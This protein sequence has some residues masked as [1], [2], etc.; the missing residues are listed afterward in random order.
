MDKIENL[1]R[2]SKTTANKIEIIDLLD[3]EKNQIGTKVII[4][5][6]NV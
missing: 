3:N 4:Q 5:L 2:L 1:N 6:E